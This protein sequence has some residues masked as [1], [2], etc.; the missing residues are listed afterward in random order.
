MNSSMM[1][2]FFTGYWLIIHL[3]CVCSRV[4]MSGSHTHKEIN[5]YF[6]YL[7]F[8]HYKNPK[9]MEYS[10]MPLAWCKKHMMWNFM[11]LMASKEHLK[12]LMM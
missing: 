7:Q 4:L 12:I 2:D 11:R 9:H 1:H 5:L 3:K 10:I 8:G 6:H